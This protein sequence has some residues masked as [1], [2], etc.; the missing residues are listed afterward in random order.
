MHH[1]AVM[2]NANDGVNNVG[3][4]P[5]IVVSASSGG[6]VVRNSANNGVGSSGGSAHV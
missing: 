5:R 3:L 1:S 2:R 4:I 6:R